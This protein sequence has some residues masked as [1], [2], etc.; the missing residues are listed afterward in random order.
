MKD[1]LRS[2]RG[3]P[4]DLLSFDQVKERLRL[5]QLVDRGVHEVPLD[6][7][8]GTVGREGQFN[9]AFLPKEESL[10]DRWEDVKDL[11]EGSA[12]FSSVELYYVNDVYF[13]VDGHHRV[14]VARTLNAETIEAR[15]KEFATPLPLDPNTSLEDLILRSA[16]LDFLETTGLTAETP[17]DYRTTTANGYERL[18]E[19]ISGHRWYL[20]LETHREPTWPEAVL[21]WRDRVYRPMVQEIRRTEILKDFPDSTETDLYLFVMDH[22]HYLREQYGTGSVAPED[23]VREFVKG[24]AKKR[25]RK[26]D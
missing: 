8:V 16:Q 9:R 1:I 26:K 22:L 4:V 20:G 11:A 3:L 25:K 13:V 17:D 7:I 15:V 12:G 6:R 23:A 19:H 10:R 2:L 24:A 14:S 18:L 21:S 5:Q